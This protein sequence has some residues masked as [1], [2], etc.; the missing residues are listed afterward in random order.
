MKF[1]FQSLGTS[2]AERSLAAR[3]PSWLGDL[4]E[5]SD[6]RHGK[7]VVSS[8]AARALP[9]YIT[10]DS[11]FPDSGDA[12]PSVAIISQQPNQERTAPRYPIGDLNKYAYNVN[13]GEGTTVYI[14]DPYQGYN[15]APSWSRLK[16][17]R[18]N[19]H[20]GRTCC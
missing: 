3:E 10:D 15:P 7:R 13:Q 18:P 16:T 17:V 2:E 6:K 4:E 1:Y 12:D 11:L 20:S 19:L 5:A 14:I 9:F 8:I